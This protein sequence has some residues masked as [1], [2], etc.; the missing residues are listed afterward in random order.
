MGFFHSYVSMVIEENLH[1][2]NA[3]LQQIK[4]V[5]WLDFMNFHIYFNKAH[6]IKDTNLLPLTIF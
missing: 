3:F 5:D 4:A 2:E 6:G 1:C